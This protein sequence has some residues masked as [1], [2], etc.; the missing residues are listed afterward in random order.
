M[1]EYFCDKI[2]KEIKKKGIV[3]VKL[4]IYDVVKKVGVLIVIVF[5]V[6]N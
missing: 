4:I 6:I 5:K 3:K 2:R 1:I